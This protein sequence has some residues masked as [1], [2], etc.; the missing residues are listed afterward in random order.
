MTITDALRMQQI[1]SL[2]E[3]N[4]KLNF[5]I[6]MIICIKRLPYAYNDLIV[7]KCQSTKT[8]LIITE[9]NN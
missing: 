6:N 2:H 7:R 9:M 1:H 3:F 4:S 8:F 5:Q